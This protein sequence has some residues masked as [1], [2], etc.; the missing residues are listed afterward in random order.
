MDSIAYGFVITGSWVKDL[1]KFPNNFSD[2]WILQYKHTT[3]EGVSK[4][5]VLGYR[6]FK[7]EKISN[8]FLNYSE[9]NEIFIKCVVEATMKRKIYNVII[10]M[11]MEAIIKCRCSCVGGIAGRCKHVFGL[12]WYLLDVVR[13]EKD[14]IEDDVACTSKNRSWRIGTKAVTNKKIF[15]L[16]FVKEDYTKPLKVTKTSEDRQNEKQRFKNNLLSEETLRRHAEYLHE[17]G[18][19]MFSEVLHHNKFLAVKFEEE[20][21]DESDHPNCLPTQSL[22]NKEFFIIARLN[23]LNVT[24]LLNFCS[25]TLDEARAIEKKTRK[26]SENQL[27]RMER[28]KRIS[29]SKF[30]N[31]VRRKA[32][33]NDK[34]LKQIWPKNYISTAMMRMGLDN[35]PVAIQKYQDITPGIKVFPSGLC[36]NPGIPYLCSS[37][38]GLVY[39]EINKDFYLIEIKTLVKGGLINKFNIIECIQ[40]GFAPFLEVVGNNIKLRN[41]HL[42]YVQI[43]GQLAITGL[44]RCD[45]IVDSGRELYIEKINFDADKWVYEYLPLL[46][47]FYFKYQNVCVNL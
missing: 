19:I 28:T 3:N 9:S 23:D 40:K 13:Q 34:L 20:K 39:D 8:V 12:L 15:Q 7:S 38:D 5:N 26:Q 24:E 47:S 29:S 33:V 21:E 42:Y 17:N 31:I 6:L 16:D 41:T 10:K 30:G 46:T 37:P 27:W 32:A 43:Q 44:K 1:G 25:V 36:I 11:S 35:E 22:W 45:L 4:P 14:Y 18:L 2:N